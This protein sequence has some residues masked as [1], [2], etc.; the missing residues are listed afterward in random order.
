[1]TAEYSGDWGTLRIET[2]MIDVTSGLPRPDH[3]WTFTDA[4]DHDHRWDDGYPTLVVVTEEPY[5]CPDCEDEHT[6]SHYECP[7]CGEVIEPGLRPAPL[8]REYVPGLTSAWLNDEP[9]SEAEAQ[10][11]VERIRNQTTK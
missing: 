1:M 11:I 10:A 4:H 3:A 9:I 5:W 2:E 7:L 6:D 8:Y